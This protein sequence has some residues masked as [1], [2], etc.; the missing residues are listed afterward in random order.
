MV[1]TTIYNKGESQ[2][3]KEAKELLEVLQNLNNAIEKIKHSNEH[4]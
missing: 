3:D 1:D 2:M 4:N